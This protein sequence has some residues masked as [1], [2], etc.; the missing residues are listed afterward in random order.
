MKLV[1]GDIS[2]HI[3]GW[4]QRGYAPDIQKRKNTSGSVIRALR[5][6][7]P[8][9]HWE[10]AG[11]PMA[12]KNAKSGQKERNLTKKVRHKY[13]IFSYYYQSPLNVSPS[14]YSVSKKQRNSSDHTDPDH[15]SLYH[16]STMCHLSFPLFVVT[17]S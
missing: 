15:H 7:Q 12:R 14:C 3:A 9:G 11:I 8:S 13:W 2:S 10:E 6:A 1:K 16:L 17:V 4:C 5:P